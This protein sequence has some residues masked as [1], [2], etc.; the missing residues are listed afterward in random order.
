LDIT[1]VPV[2]LRDEVHA[3]VRISVG[4]ALCP[5]SALTGEALLRAADAAMYVA[6]AA[7][8]GYHIHASD[9]VD[10]K[11]SDRKAV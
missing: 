7:G 3:S 9:D 2:L 11:S 8:G 5:A 1:K 10:A 6:K 4:I